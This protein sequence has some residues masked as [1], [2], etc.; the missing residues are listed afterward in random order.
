M[1]PYTFIP[2]QDCGEPLVPI[3]PE[4]FSLVQ[5]HPYEKLGAP[6]E[7]KSPFYVREGVL[8]GL[9]KAHGF[10]QEEHPGWR[11]QVFDAYRPIAVQQFMVD[12][13][14]QELLQTQGL[15]QERLTE[16]QRQEILNQVYQF[17]AVPSPD[18]ATPPPHS[19]GAAVDITL[20]DEAETAIDMGSPIDEISPRSFPNYFANSHLPQEKQL[21]RHRQLLHNIMTT[22]GFKQHPNEWWHFCLGDQMWAWLTNQE[23]PELGAIARYGRWEVEGVRG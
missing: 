21:H 1:K 3:S 14:F 10:L 5:P 4:N 19:T 22:A 7:G 9:L 15:S 20:V 11:I 13:T 12:Y 23:K 18:P 6:Y 8:N 17:W 16:H 2:I